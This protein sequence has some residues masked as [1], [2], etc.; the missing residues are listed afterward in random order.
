MRGIVICVE[1]DDI[2]RITLPMAM[3]HMEECLVVTSPADERT[4]ELVRSTYG[5]KIHITDAFYRGNAR[6]NKGAAMEEGFDALGRDGWILVWD[7]DIV[8]PD[9]LPVG[10]F[11]DLDRDMLY[12]CPRRVLDDPRRWHPG[13]DWSLATLQQ[14]RTFPG[15]FQLFHADC[16][17]LAGVRP[18]YGT[19]WGHCGGCDTVFEYHWPLEKRIKMHGLQVLHLGPRDTNWFG[20]VSGRLDGTSI[21]GTAER[22]HDMREL[23][24]TH[25]WTQW[26]RR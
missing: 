13:F 22:Q 25:G 14:E 4:Q 19:E 16:R 24:K 9:H 5:A 17:Y 7:A 23:V 10:Q 26:E 21:G 8:F 20:R 1:Y 12:N 15:Y 6:F 11:Q 3:R 2:L 18:W